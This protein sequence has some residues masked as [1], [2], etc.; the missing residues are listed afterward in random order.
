MEN[1]VFHMIYNAVSNVRIFFEFHGNELLKSSER[2]STIN[3]CEKLII[4]LAGCDEYSVPALNLDKKRNCKV[5][6]ASTDKESAIYFYCRASQCGVYFHHTSAKT[7][8]KH[9]LNR[10]LNDL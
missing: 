4:N 9:D 2:Y 7:C 6:Y 8:L 3:F 5:C 1:I 10:T